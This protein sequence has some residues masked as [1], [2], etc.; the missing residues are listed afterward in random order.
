[1]NKKLE[2]VVTKITKTL[3]IIA[4][5]ISI[6]GVYKI[7]QMSLHRNDN[8]IQIEVTPPI[9]INEKVLKLSKTVT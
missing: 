2:N 9:E 4:W 3:F 7:V 8:K 1:M 5:I 6:I